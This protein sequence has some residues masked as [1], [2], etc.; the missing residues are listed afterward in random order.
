MSA[1]NE[2]KFLVCFTVSLRLQI[3]EAIAATFDNLQAIF[4]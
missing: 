1:F 2:D 4:C 3:Y